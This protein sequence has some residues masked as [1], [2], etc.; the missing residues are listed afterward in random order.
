MIN[1]NSWYKLKSLYYIY[2]SVCNICVMCD[3]K[4]SPINKYTT[5]QFLTAYF[6]KPKIP[7]F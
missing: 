1:W 2:M 7:K 4:V 3:Y 6:S 5:Q